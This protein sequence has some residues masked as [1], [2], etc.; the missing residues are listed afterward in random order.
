VNRIEN[1]S[2]L[3]ERIYIENKEIIK[4]RERNIKSIGKCGIKWK[5]QLK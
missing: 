4:E 3:Q 1:K 5:N 2:F